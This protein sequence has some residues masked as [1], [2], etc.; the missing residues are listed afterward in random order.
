MGARHRGEDGDEHYQD[1]A[2]RDGA[3]VQRYPRISAGE[4]L[5][6]DPGADDGGD[7]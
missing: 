7:E 5:G 2:D 3:V 4:A 6:H 1:C